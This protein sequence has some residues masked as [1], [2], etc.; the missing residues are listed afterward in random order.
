MGNP[1]GD[2]GK[3]EGETMGKLTALAVE[4][5]A[6]AGLYSDGDGLYLQLKGGKSWLFKFSLD[7]KPHEMGL[8]ST[9]AISLKEARALAAEARTL[10]AKKINP[11]EQRRSGRLAE[12][13]ANAKTTTFAQ[14]GEQYLIAHEA[15]WRSAKHRQQWRTTLA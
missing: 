9:K 14:C 6:K 5:A 7:G 2:R 4:R 13:I 15:G 8:G 3:S 10:C 1:L 11:I 12:R